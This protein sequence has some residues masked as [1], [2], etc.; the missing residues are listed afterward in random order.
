MAWVR[1]AVLFSSFWSFCW[2]L[3]LL[4]DVFMKMYLYH[5]LQFSTSFAAHVDL[6]D[7]K[8]KCV[9]LCLCMCVSIVS[10]VF[11]MPISVCNN[12]MKMMVQRFEGNRIY[13]FFKPQLML[14]WTP[15]MV[16]NFKYS[17]PKFTNYTLQLSCWICILCQWNNWLSCDNCIQYYPYYWN[18]GN[19]MISM[20]NALLVEKWCILKRRRPFYR[21][22][23][24]NKL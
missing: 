15:Y 10:L 20:Y 3:W 17:L 4:L 24:K 18:F 14:I 5:E 22:E 2:L 11:S 1:I 6:C 21:H 12:I 8:G 23:R 7:K 9:S 19:E 16:W 13:M